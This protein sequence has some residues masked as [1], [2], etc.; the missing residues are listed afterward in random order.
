[1]NQSLLTSAATNG[2]ERFF[3]LQEVAAALR[4]ST[5]TLRR[6]MDARKIAYSRI[7]SCVR[8]GESDIE[9]FRKQYRFESKG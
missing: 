5:R 7:G 3:T 6:W 9:R 1:M 4:V 2:L 8:F